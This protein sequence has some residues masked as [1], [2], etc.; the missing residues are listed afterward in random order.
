MIGVP[1]PMFQLEQCLNLHLAEQM[2]GHLTQRILSSS[3]DASRP[4]ICRAQ[5]VA[6]R[7]TWQSYVQPT[8][9]FPL[10]WHGTAWHIA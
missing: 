7:D 8:C 9:T 10:A 6:R 2:T 5:L 3:F 1:I 4:N